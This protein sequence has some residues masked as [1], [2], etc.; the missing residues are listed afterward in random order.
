MSAGNPGACQAAE[1]PAQCDE[2]ADALDDRKS[3]GTIATAGFI[4]AGV[5]AAAL[6]TTWLLWPSSK[7]TVAIQLRPR[8]VGWDLRAGIRF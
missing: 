3:N 2:L 8:G 1:R 4:G 5:S 6:V 7:H